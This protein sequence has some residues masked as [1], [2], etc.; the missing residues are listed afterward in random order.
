MPSTKAIIVLMAS[1]LW[2]VILFSVVQVEAATTETF[3]PINSGSLRP[4]GLKQ[5][6]MQVYFIS[7]V[8]SVAFLIF[9]ASGTLPE[10]CRVE[11]VTLRVKVHIAFDANWLSAYSWADFWANYTWDEY[12]QD[13]EAAGENNLVGSKWVDQ[14]DTW[15]TFPFPS[16]DT[17]INAIPLMPITVDLESSYLGVNLPQ[18]VISIEEA[19]LVVTY[20]LVT[21]TPTPSPTATPTPSPSPSPS[22]SL[23]PSPSSTPQL[24]PTVQPDTGMFLPMPIIYGIVIAFVILM[25]IIIVLIIRRK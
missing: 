17:I 12:T 25:V 1:L 22:P 18:T 16:S 14:M 3:T 19:Q 8:K 4:Q 6:E 15:Y 21:P 7:G 5:E 10:N 9:D 24:T 20:S 11:S 13:K 2:C 23:F